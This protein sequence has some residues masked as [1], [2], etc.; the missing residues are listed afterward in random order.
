MLTHR[1]NPPTPSPAAMSQDSA[2]TVDPAVKLVD[3]FVPPSDDEGCAPQPDIGDVTMRITDETA[4]NKGETELGRDEP[5]SS[6]KPTVIDAVGSDVVDGGETGILAV[7]AKTVKKK[8]PG[9]G[10]LHK[11]K[12]PAAAKKPAAG[13]TNKA[14]PTKK[15]AAPAFADESDEDDSDGDDDILVAKKPA[16][17]G[18]RKKGP[19]KK[20]VKFI[21]K[22]PP[23]KK[24]TPPKRA[25]KFAAKENVAES[26]D[27]ESDVE[28]GAVSPALKESINRGNAN[29]GSKR[30]SAP[31]KYVAKSKPV[32]TKTAEPVE[33]K[34]AAM[35][36]KAVGDEN[37]DGSPTK[38]PKSTLMKKRLQVSR[39][40]PAKK[41]KLEKGK[42]G[43]AKVAAVTT[44]AVKPKK[45]AKKGKKKEAEND[46]SDE[47]DGKAVVDDGEDDDDLPS[48][49]ESED[50]ECDVNSSAPVVKH[51]PI[52]CQGVAFSTSDEVAAG[53]VEAACTQL[54]GYAARDASKADVF[55][56]SPG[57]KRTGSLLLA[58][59]RG[60]PVLDIEWLSKS[61]ECGKFVQDVSKY[62]THVGARASRLTR[63]S[64]NSAGFLKRARV[65][66]EGTPMS[67]T[68][69]LRKIVQQCGGKIV[70][71]KEHFAIVDA[72]REEASRSSNPVLLAYLADSIEQQK[73]LPEAN[74]RPAT[75]LS[76]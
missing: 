46:V 23:K 58:I 34:A 5:V 7:K 68:M 39:V 42:R 40:V 11:V 71:D 44:K 61:I 30:K 72:K 73:L 12:K 41:G 25:K 48:D 38:K 17:A 31:K 13:K 27:E 45:A 37:D 10:P 18:G 74:Y 36:R 3:A 65:K 76:A 33:K 62:E 6:D 57:S 20:P 52:A 29:G 67:D 69:L 14:K 8:S 56:R 63:E 49:V 1:A 54:T 21:K 53:L 70:E 4:A 2:R 75:F 66:I 32:V 59:A 51:K 64:T 60:I 50:E 28:A 24:T 35:K 19:P 22:T 26:S 47:E 15:Q 16:A 9:K 55:V 43:N